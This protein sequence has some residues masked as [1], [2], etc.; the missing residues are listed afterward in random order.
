MRSFIKDKKENPEFM[1]GGI[2][3]YRLSDGTVSAKLLVSLEK[4]RLEDSYE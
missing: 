2:I 1:R 4:Y 3:T